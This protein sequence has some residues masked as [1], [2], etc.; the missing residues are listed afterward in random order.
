MMIFGYL[1]LKLSKAVIELTHFHLAV[2][3]NL[4][5]VN[6]C[7]CFA[8]WRLD[9]SAHIKISEILIEDSQIG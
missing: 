3:L 8:I 1:S 9:T 2:K 5:K 4:S 7:I 6:F